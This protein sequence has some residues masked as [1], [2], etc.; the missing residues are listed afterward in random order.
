[1]LWPSNTFVDFETGMS[2][3]VRKLREALGDSAD[4]PL[5]V[6]TLPRRGYRFIAPLKELP[7]TVELAGGVDTRP[8]KPSPSLSWMAV[9]AIA[10]AIAIPFLAT[11]LAGGRRAA[12]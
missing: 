12:V 6:E 8:T 3:A 9:A 1:R 11:M 2:S 7:L 4:H 5:F 10:S